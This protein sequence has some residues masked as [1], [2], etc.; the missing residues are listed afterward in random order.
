MLSTV[1]NSLSITLL[2]EG[3]IFVALAVGVRVGRRVRRSDR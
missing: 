3:G 2:V 1:F